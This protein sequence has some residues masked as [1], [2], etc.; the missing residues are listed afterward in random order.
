MGIG[1]G[2]GI[3]LAF[4]PSHLL[5]LAVLV[6]PVLGS[7]EELSHVRQPGRAL[8]R[9]FFGAEEPPMPPANLL[10]FTLTSGGAIMDSLLF[11]TVG[12]GVKSKEQAIAGRGMMRS[13]AGSPL[14]HRGPNSQERMPLAESRSRL[15]QTGQKRAVWIQVSG[16]GPCLSPGA[17][18][19]MLGWGEKPLR[20]ASPCLFPTLWI[21]H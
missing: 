13:Q 14:S 7:L 18:S 6:G 3:L 11:Y 19:A 21:Q 16:P 20:A 12:L 9:A 4:F 10:G 8:E 5:V 17:A 2:G 15:P 1:C